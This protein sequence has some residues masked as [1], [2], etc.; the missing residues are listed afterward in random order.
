[1]ASLNELC[2]PADRP[3]AW[4]IALLNSSDPM[5][6]LASSLRFFSH[7]ATRSRQA[8]AGS[9]EGGS[10]MMALLFADWR[11]PVS[12]CALPADRHWAL[13]CDRP[14]AAETYRRVPAFGNKTR[15]TGSRR[16][17]GTGRSPGAFEAGG[18]IGFNPREAT[19]G[20]YHGRAVA[21]FYEHVH[22]T[23]GGPQV[24]AGRYGKADR[25]PSQE[26]RRVGAFGRSCIGRRE[27]A[28]GEAERDRRR[29]DPRDQ[30]DG[31]RLQAR[32]PAGSG[33]QASRA[34]QKGVRG[35]DPEHRRRRTARSEIE[36]RCSENHSGANAAEL[37]G[38]SRQRRKEIGRLAAP[39]RAA[40]RPGISPGFPP[41]VGAPVKS[42]RRKV[43]T[44]RG[45]CGSSTKHPEKIARS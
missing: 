44:R 32:E 27:V 3:M 1:M 41:G 12:R 38:N 16:A 42:A 28:G 20:G 26:Y 15:E 18:Q 34:C 4:L 22:E 25:S 39:L 24:T 19:V 2:M 13:G 29:G 23:R 30:R 43:E 9:F 6:R 35:G 14:H 37:R 10:A 11:W 40:A 45:S 21:I 5:V 31:A 8:A 17:V 7:W 36:R 33:R